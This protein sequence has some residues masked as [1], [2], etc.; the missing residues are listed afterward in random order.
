MTCHR[1]PGGIVDSRYPLGGHVPPPIR[2]LAMERGDYEI[3]WAGPVPRTGA[4]YV[5]TAETWDPTMSVRTILAWEPVEDP[6]PA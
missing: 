6:C 1:D 3:V 4:P 5:V 2:D